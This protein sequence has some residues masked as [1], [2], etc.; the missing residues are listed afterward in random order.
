MELLNKTIKIIIAISSFDLGGAERQAFQFANYINNRNIEEVEIFGFSNPGKI[1][2]L[3]DSNK[4]KWKRI[5]Q[6]GFIFSPVYIIRLFQLIIIF[7]KSKPDIIMSYTHGP[8]FLCSLIWRW[9][10]ST[11][12]VWNQRDEGLH[13]KIPLFVKWTIKK[14]SGFISN[15]NLGAQYLIRNFKISD[16]C[17]RIIPNGIKLSEPL[18]DRNEWCK[19]LKIGNNTLTACMVANL[20]E[21]KDHRTLLKSWKKVV[22]FF[23]DDVD[24][25]VLVLAGKEYE[26]YNELVKVSHEKNI[27]KYVRFLGQVEDISGLLNTVDLGVLISKSEGCSNG[28]L[29]CMASGLA[30]IATDI[31]ANREAMGNDNMYCLVSDNDS[32]TLAEKLIEFLK[33]E[34]IR[35]K[36]GDLNK[37]RIYEKFSFENSNKKALNYLL[38]LYQLKK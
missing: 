34:H 26:T 7:R 37:K 18:K 21:R 32:D 12:Y 36:Y 33:N 3:C 11:I 10:G 9:T 20:T 23:S 22:D 24:I 16:D 30:V 14:I 4:I 28:L 35:K 15:S 29:E 13:Y 27:L 17:V 31:P 38:S 8:N 19:L 2:Q 5:S 25:P 1:S 6:P